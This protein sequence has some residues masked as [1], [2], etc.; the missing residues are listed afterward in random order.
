MD[1][2]HRLIGFSGSGYGQTMEEELV[3]GATWVEEVTEE[4]GI[5]RSGLLQR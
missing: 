3:E 2:L 4:L 1:L 5:P